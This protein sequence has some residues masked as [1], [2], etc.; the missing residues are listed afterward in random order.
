MAASRSKAASRSRGAAARSELNGRAPRVTFHKLK[1]DLPP[2]LPF[3]VAQYLSA[4][5]DV[6]GEQVVALLE[7]VLGEKQMEKVW[8]VDIDVSKAAGGLGAVGKALN[9][10]LED[11]I[12]AYGVT[13]GE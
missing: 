9:G 1:L 12:E 4:G 5:N 8:A 10:L 2:V 7:T 3:R 6:T 11:I 13:A